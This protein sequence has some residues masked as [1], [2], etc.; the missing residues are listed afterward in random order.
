[1]RLPLCCVIMLAIANWS[2]AALARDAGDMIASSAPRQ[3]AASL[4]AADAGD[5]EKTLADILKERAASESDVAQAT[6]GI[7]IEQAEPTHYAEDAW[8]VFRWTRRI[9]GWLGISILAVVS[10]LFAAMLPIVGRV[11]IFIGNALDRAIPARNQP[12]TG[13]DRLAGL[14]AQRARRTH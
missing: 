11:L 10:T 2:S 4:P 13:V 8:F 6:A 12:N 14:Q 7:E 5:H 1:M 9:S 3:V